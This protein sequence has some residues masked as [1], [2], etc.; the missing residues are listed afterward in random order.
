MARVAE[1]SVAIDEWRRNLPFRVSPPKVWPV[2]VTATGQEANTRLGTGSPASGDSFGHE[3]CRKGV[4]SHQ[5]TASVPLYSRSKAPCACRSEQK[6]GHGLQLQSGG[7]TLAH[8]CS[9]G[10]ERSAKT[11]ESFEVA[12]DTHHLPYTGMLRAHL[13]GGDY[14]PDSSRGS[15]SI[16]AMTPSSPILERCRAS[17]DARCTPGA[18]D[19]SG[20]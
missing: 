4:F 10:Y 7:G 16:W 8:I 17:L 2:A 6:P 5:K 13:V 9:T 12:A 1:G 20:P 14:R 11:K 18:Q 3:S 19:T 15:A